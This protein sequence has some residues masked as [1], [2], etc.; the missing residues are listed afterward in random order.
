MIQVDAFIAGNLIEI[1]RVWAAQQNSFRHGQK[2]HFW[3]VQRILQVTQ[4]I[5]RHVCKLCFKE[6]QRILQV[7]QHMSYTIAIL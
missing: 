6:A 4:H 2:L 3:K 5:F 7:T 1:F